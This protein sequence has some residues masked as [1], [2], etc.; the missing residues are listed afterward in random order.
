MFIVFLSL[1]GCNF[2]HVVFFFKQKTAYE[3]RI[4]DWSSDVCSSDLR[5]GRRIG[6]GGSKADLVDKDHVQRLVDA[7]QPCAA[8]DAE[9]QRR[10]QQDVA[11]QR[12][13]EAGLLRA[14]DHGLSSP[15]VTRATLLRPARLSSPITRMTRP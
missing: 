5:L 14:I 9:R 1:S 13:A 3:M 7:G 6:H 11:C 12:D 2:F 15:A 10:E 4:S 8:E